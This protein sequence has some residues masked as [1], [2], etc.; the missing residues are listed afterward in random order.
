[1]WLLETSTIRLTEFLGTDPPSYAI[2]SHV[3]GNEEVSYQELQLMTDVSY[4]E[5]QLMT[6]V[7]YQ[8]IQ[9]MTDAVRR[10]AGYKKIEKFCEVVKNY[11]FGYA[12]VDTCC[13]DKRSSAELNE[14][15]NSMYRWYRNASMCIIHLADVPRITSN[16]G[17]NSTLEALTTSRWFRRG[18][19]LQELLA[20]SQR[21]VF[22]SDW[23]A[24]GAGWVDAISIITNISPIVLK[25]RDKLNSFCIAER[26]SWAAHRQTTRPEDGAYSLMG[27]FNVSMPILYGEGA[28]SAFRRLQVEIMKTSF[29][30]TIFA[31]RGNYQTS[32]LLAKSPSDFATTPKLGLQKPNMLAPFVMTNVGLSITLSLLKS[33]KDH[34]HG[35]LQAALQCDIMINQAWEILLI[36]LKKI[37]NARCIVNG[38][39]CQGYIRVDCDNWD[40]ISKRDLDGCVHEQILVFE[41]EHFEL[42]EKSA[43]EDRDR[44]H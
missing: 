40:T 23:S 33:T 26:M 15:I 43:K 19:T 12:W 29:D 24:L 37:E 41:K 6:D 27:L 1:M 39:Y 16:S 20:C 14:A 18:W 22:T 42:I 35:T 10:K 25:D 28:Q 5:L 7:T 44:W 32:G 13:I 9:L 17:P 11:G 38:K 36:R 21:Q 3:W 34:E 2:L 30:Q 8:K 4:Q 31:W